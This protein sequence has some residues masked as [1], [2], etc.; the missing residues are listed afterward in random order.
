MERKRRCLPTSMTVSLFPLLQ[1]LMAILIHQSIDA[2]S[3]YEDNPGYNPPRWSFSNDSSRPVGEQAK[4]TITFDVPYDLRKLQATLLNFNI[5]TMLNT[6]YLQ[7]IPSS[8]TTDLPTCKAFLPV[9]FDV[10]LSGKSLR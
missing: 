2:L 4:C 3:S 1:H 9:H 7:I 10:L 8:S 5:D 6:R